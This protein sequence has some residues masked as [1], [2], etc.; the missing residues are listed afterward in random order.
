VTEAQ[1][2]VVIDDQY[3]N[4]RLAYWARIAMGQ[5]EPLRGPLTDVAFGPIAAIVAC[6]SY[7]QIG[8]QEPARRLKL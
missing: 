8:G 3:A 2:S 1:R 5:L 6:P 4:R 7:R